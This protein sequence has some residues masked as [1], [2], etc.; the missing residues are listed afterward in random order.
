[1]GPWGM[2]LEE[3]IGSIHFGEKKCVC[4]VHIILAVSP[5]DHVYTSHSKPPYVLLMKSRF[6]LLKSPFLLVQS[7]FLP[8]QSET[9]SEMCE[10][11]R[12][13]MMGKFTGKPYI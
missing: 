2:F 10:T 11:H 8:H 12:C 6:L 7:P 5:F 4:Y 1:M 13:W 9:R 3:M